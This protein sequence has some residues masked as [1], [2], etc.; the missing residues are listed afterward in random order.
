MRPLGPDSQPGR[1]QEALVVT[2]VG[3][4][5]R[6]HVISKVRGPSLDAPE[7]VGEGTFR[8]YSEKW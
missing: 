2:V 6:H 1:S 5:D 3:G 4:Q 7:D 8:A